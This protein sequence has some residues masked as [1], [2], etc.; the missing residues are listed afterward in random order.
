MLKRIKMK[1][2]K[3]QLIALGLSC[4]LSTQALAGDDK[5]YIDDPTYYGVES[6]VESGVEKSLQQKEYIEKYEFYITPAGPTENAQKEK[7]EK[8]EGILEKE[9]D[10][11][12]SY[13]MERDNGKS[14]LIIRCYKKKDDQLWP[15]WGFNM[16][17]VCNAY[18]DRIKRLI[19]ADDAWFITEFSDGGA[20]NKKMSL[21]S[22]EEIVSILK[23]YIKDYNA[24]SC[25]DW[26]LFVQK[27]GLRRR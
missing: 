26:N 8:L 6:V 9:C 15:E 11:A 7:G 24:N 27:E 25:V 20:N 12:D 16:S 2:N 5:I 22:A 23:D 3:I 13:L 21:S 17:L 14:D 1:A 4:G 18:F 10:Y 19:S